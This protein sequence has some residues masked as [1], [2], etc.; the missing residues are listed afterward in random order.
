MNAPDPAPRALA[1]LLHEIPD[2][3]VPSWADRV[4]VGGVAS[5]VQRVRPGDL[6]VAVD[7]VHVD[8]HDCVGEAVR[9]GA[10]AIVAERSVDAGD[11]PVLRVA[12]SRRTLA[13]L[14]AAWFDRPAD[15][16]RLVGI[17]GS[18]GKTSTLMMLESILGGSDGAFGVIGSLGARLGDRHER[19]RLTTPDAWDLHRILNWMVGAGA[20]RV[21]M[22]ATS[23]ALAQERV[24][25]LDYELGVFTN[26]VPLEHGE[27]HGSFRRYV[28]TKLGF[29]RHLARGAPVI[30]ASGNRAVRAAVESHDVHGVGCGAG[31]AADVR[32]RHRGLGAEGTEVDLQVRRPLPRVDG[33]PLPPTRFDVRL[34]LLGLPNVINAAIAAATALSLGAPVERIRNGLA[35]VRAPRRRMEIV[36]RGDPTVLDDTVGHPDSISAVFEVARRLGHERRY[37]AYAIRG[38]RGEEINRR[39]AEAVAIWLRRVPV[40]RLVVTSS[41]DAADEANRVEPAERRIFEETLQRYGVAHLY[42][43]R[44][45]DAIDTV[46]DGIA[47]GDL[48][49]LLGAQGMDA[50]AAVLR[51]RLGEAGAGEAG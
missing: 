28:E 15:G 42:R 4:R 31:D 24:H 47:Q 43:D 12:S 20:E 39:D 23:H 14:A 21:A 27:Y 22:E 33:D 17:T 26:L 1:K 50:G 37:V 18:L 44:L 10:R 49:L 32:V 48:L 9:R 46:L 11:T 38:G 16:L 36:R 40:H 25:G 41:V 6:F 3:A 34:R 2:V 45:D 8:G 35:G 5:T 19:T 30:H 51:D 7:G 29:F 13:A